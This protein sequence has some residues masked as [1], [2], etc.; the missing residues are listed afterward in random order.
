M[1]GLDVIYRDEYRLE[2]FLGDPLVAGSPYSYREIVAREE[3]PGVPDG[4][5]ELIETWH[6][7][8]Y[9]V[10]EELGGRLRCLDEVF[11]LCRALSRH[12]VNL[13]ALFGSTETVLEHKGG[14]LRLTGTKWPA[15]NAIRGRFV[16]TFARSGPSTFSLVLVDKTRLPAQSWSTRPFIPMV[17]LKRHDVSGIEFRDAP[18]TGD[19]FIGREGAGLAQVLKGLQVTRYFARDDGRGTADHPGLRVP[20]A[21]LR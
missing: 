11:L 1:A 5:R 8:E 21:A 12:D 19:V 17:G 16:T 9:L 10:P 3:L 7:N 14:G 13:A 6:Y 2:E 4:T 15:G 18:L 20:A